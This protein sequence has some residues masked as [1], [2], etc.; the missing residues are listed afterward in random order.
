LNAST[1]DLVIRIEGLPQN[2]S[3]ISPAVKALAGA[4]PAHTK[5]IEA[6]VGVIKT[7]NTQAPPETP[8]PFKADGPDTNWQAQ[9]PPSPFE[10]GE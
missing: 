9:I 5:Q 6:L 3:G 8:E 1:A 10:E 2:L 7:A 4:L